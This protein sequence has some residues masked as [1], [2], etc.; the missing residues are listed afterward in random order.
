MGKKERA[1]FTLVELLVVIAIIAL[2]VQLLLPA[3]QAARESARRTQCQNHVKQLALAAQMHV[4]AHK[5]FPTG[6]WSDVFV[7]D[8]RRGYGKE[9]PGSWLFSLL[10]YVEESSLRAAGGEQVDAVPLGPG[11]TA[12]YQSA[13]TIFYCPS[14][15]QAQAYPF[16]RAGNGPWS[17]HAGQG[18]L[19]L[20]A[21]TK[22][23]YA[24]NSG[25]AIYSAAE[26]FSDEQAMW[27]PAS[28]ESLKTEPQQW[29]ETTN[30]QNSY[31][32]SGVSYYRSEV[33]PAQIQDGLSKTYLCGEKFLA[34]EFYEDVNVSD[35]PAIFGDNQSA[36]AGF[37]WDNHR[38]AWNANSR[39]S[40]ET[41]QPRQ[42]TPGYELAGCFA[43]G[44]AHAGALN[45]A[46]CDGS[47]QRIGYD[48]D[49]EVHRQQA[50]RLD[51]N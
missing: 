33:K 2:L 34:P 41:Y 39:W 7:A 30:R 5:F 38:V 21:V 26:P 40:P 10:E 50:N 28:Y 8:P 9:Q 43:F 29:T 22:S 15:R 47:V 12:L 16:K 37:D 14:R 32:Q 11:L 25:D 6:G 48:I 18:V 44:S 24:V 35:S 46:F 13:P 45:M 27:V 1:G 20:A 19:K 3:I 36:W 31:F 51:G 17:L 42:D 23:D 49:F 4:D